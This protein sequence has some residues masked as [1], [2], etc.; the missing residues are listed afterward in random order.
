MLLNSPDS[1]PTAIGQDGAYA[2]RAIVLITCELGYVLQ[3]L[4]SW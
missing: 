2:P 4:A 1:N 3:T